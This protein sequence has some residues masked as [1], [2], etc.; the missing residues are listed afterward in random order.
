MTRVCL[1]FLESSLKQVLLALCSLTTGPFLRLYLLIVPFYRIS[2]LKL[3]ILCTNTCKNPDESVLGIDFF[4][5]DLLLLAE[6][7]PSAQK[8]NKLT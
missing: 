8:P 2:S 3:L 1:C 5:S 6:F 4:G 7:D